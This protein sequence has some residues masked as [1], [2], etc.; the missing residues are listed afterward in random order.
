MTEP[1]VFRYYYPVADENGGLTSGY[2][3][4]SYSEFVKR[5]GFSPF[6][7]VMLGS[8]EHR[9]AQPEMYAFLGC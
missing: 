4:L 3:L 8:S 5:T 7:G 6:D 9:L 2:D 1:K